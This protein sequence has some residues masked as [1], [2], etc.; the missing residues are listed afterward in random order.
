M[1]QDWLLIETLGSEP[2]VVAVGK[3]AKKMIPVP[4]ILSKNRHL[5][6]VADAIKGSISARTPA[7]FPVPGTDR[8]IHTHPLILTTGEVHGTH[9]WLGNKDME[10][11]ARPPAGAWAWNLSTGGVNL[12]AEALTVNGITD[13]EPGEGG[14]IA[15]SFRFI[16]P[17]PDEADALAKLV[18][19]EDGASHCAT[20]VGK[21]EDQQLRRVHFSARILVDPSTSHRLVRGLNINTGPD[22]PVT[23]EQ[24]PRIL[25]QR[26]L[27]ATA[28]PGTYR[29]IINLRDLTLL[30]WVDEPMPEIAW[31]YDPENNRKLHPDDIPIARDMKSGLRDTPKT[32]GVLRIRGTNGQWVRVHVT[33]NLTLLNE[34]TNAA[35]VTIKL[36]ET[37]T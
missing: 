1:A 34:Y 3:Q 21:G 14:N 16:E 35:L 11:P 22:T 36:V 27:A 17:N 8:V 4:A 15:E 29:A 20:W 32:E 6:V 7:L 31:G 10:P 23:P 33:A 5:P 24:R 2:T 19:A 18:N 25:E 30:K 13:R 9:L 26:L 12:N 28:E 37:N